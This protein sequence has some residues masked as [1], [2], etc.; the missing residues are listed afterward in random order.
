MS[1]RRLSILLLIPAI[2]VAEWAHAVV[3]L[4]SMPACEITTIRL[5]ESAVEVANVFDPSQYV[6]FSE[7][8]FDS[9]SACIC[10]PLPVLCTSDQLLAIQAILDADSDGDG[11]P[12]CVDIC[13]SVGNPNQDNQDGDAAG[14]ACESPSCINNPGCLPVDLIDFTVE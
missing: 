13:P 10:P 7:G 12:D 4:V 9:I 8:I 14:D 11:I 2:L 3:L 6:V 5:F 1:S